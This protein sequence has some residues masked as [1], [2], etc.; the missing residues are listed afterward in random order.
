MPFVIFSDE[1][2]FVVFD[3]KKDVK[4]WRKINCEHAGHNLITTVKHDG[5][6]VMEWRYMAAGG[7]GNLV[8]IENTMIRR[9]YLNI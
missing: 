4:V 7:V 6:S 5:G 2:K 1:S 9:D 3:Q 8:F